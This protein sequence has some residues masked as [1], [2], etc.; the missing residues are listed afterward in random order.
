MRSDENKNKWNGFFFHFYCL[1]FEN[2]KNIKSS[3]S[4]NHYIVIGD[5]LIKK[6]DLRSIRP[7]CPFCV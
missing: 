4:F 5:F 1:W 2:F 7:N 6:A 3:L